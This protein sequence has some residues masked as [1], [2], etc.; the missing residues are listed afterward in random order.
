MNTDV[1]RFC[2][3]VY[4]QFYTKNENTQYAK[5][6]RTKDAISWNSKKANS[7]EQYYV[8]NITVSSK[9]YKIHIYPRRYCHYKTIYITRCTNVLRIYRYQKVCL[10]DS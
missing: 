7:N 6:N 9:R 2:T 1:D 5:T 8:R 3:D 4:K 10:R